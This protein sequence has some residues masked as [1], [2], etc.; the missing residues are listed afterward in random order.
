MKN[1]QACLLCA[2][3]FQVGGLDYSAKRGHTTIGRA[4]CGFTCA[5]MVI[6]TWKDKNI[7]PPK[8][9]AS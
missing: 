7:T 6:A 8:T 5:A 4:G 2:D 3:R 1:N 9:G